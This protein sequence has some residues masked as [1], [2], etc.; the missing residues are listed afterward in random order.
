MT[1]GETATLRIAFLRSVWRSLRVTWPIL[2][3]LLATMAILGATVGLIEGWGFAAGI[4]FAFVTGLTIG[5]GDL[6]PS[7]AVTRILAVGIGL[8]GIVLTGVVAAVAV[9]AL[10]SPME[11]PASRE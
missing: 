6:A 9:A 3:G 2:S 8:L 4:Y 11:G 1:F 10:R 7:M 5:Y